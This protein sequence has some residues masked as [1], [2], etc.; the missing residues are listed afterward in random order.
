VGAPNLS[1]ISAD[2]IPFFQPESQQRSES[3]STPPETDYSAWFA[4]IPDAILPP[5]ANMFARASALPLPQSQA[6]GLFG[7]SSALPAD[8]SIRTDSTTSVSNDSED[9]PVLASQTALMHVPMTGFV[10]ASHK[11]FLAPSA[12]AFE[13][14]QQKLRAWQEGDPD[15]DVVSTGSL[16]AAQSR[17]TPASKSPQRGLLT[18]V[19]EDL[20]NEDFF[21]VD[22]PGRIT[23]PDTPTPAGPSFSRASGMADLP[24][25][26]IPSLGFNAGP[27]GGVKQNA[28]VRPK[29][30]KSPLLQHKGPTSNM[31]AMGFTSS[32][33]NPNRPQ[34]SGAGFGFGPA[35]TPHPLA[36]PPL[37]ASG[38]AT[39]VRPPP[40]LPDGL[41]TAG[42]VTPMRP[43]L[44]GTHRTTNSSSSAIRSTPAK[45]VPPFK[46]GMRPGEKGRLALEGTKNKELALD[47]SS[48]G[49][50]QSAGSAVVGTTMTRKG[51]ARWKAFDL[52]RFL[53]P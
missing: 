5:T 30:F 2:Y 49:P 26:S 35:S 23:M 47:A 13:L 12:E 53:I 34:I 33:L 7:L 4:P 21:S 14:A 25:F 48:M 24:S 45:F 15:P 3:P 31:T 1:A 40:S 27:I 8:T 41:G 28:N 37:T 50:T 32:P 20:D 11:G 42:F 46:A 22:S 16:P 43:L 38:T 10:K 17:V 36:G 52:S 29:P 6:I 19:S 39:P 9:A 44:G 51:K 18:T